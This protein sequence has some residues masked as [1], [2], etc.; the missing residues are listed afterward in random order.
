MPLPR[1]WA[2]RR[3]QGK[4]RSSAP[5]HG[6]V[7]PI[8]SEP[9]PGSAKCLHFAPS[10]RNSYQHSLDFV[11]SRDTRLKRGCSGSREVAPSPALCR[12]IDFISRT[13][14]NSHMYAHEEL[15]P[16]HRRCCPKSVQRCRVASGIPLRR[17][18]PSGT[19]LAQC[20]QTSRLIM[21]RTTLT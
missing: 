10:I 11:Q 12:A 21:P 17:P 6:I 13:Q 18:S 9:W 19:V 16:L 3:I 14:T 4:Q 15:C 7:R 5:R 2:A 20:S 8:S 1:L